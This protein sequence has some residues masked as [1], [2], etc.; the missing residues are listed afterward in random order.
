MLSSVLHGREYIVGDGGHDTLFIGG[1]DSL[2]ACGGN[3]GL[4]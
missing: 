2:N 1:F 3:F 4:I